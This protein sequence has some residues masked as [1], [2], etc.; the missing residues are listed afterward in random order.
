MT[1]PAWLEGLRWTTSVLGLL[2]LGT[3]IHWLVR[4]LD[5]RWP[6]APPRPAPRT[7]GLRLK[8]QKPAPKAPRGRSWVACLLTRR[9][10]NATRQ[11]LGGFRCPDCGL[12]AA[13]LSEMGFPSGYIR[14]RIE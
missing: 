5:E 6:E 8:V 10:P 13:D 11:V 2:L 4:L 3:G 9:H 12:A 14:R 1:P 7:V